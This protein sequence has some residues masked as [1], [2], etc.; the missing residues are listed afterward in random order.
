LSATIKPAKSVVPAA[1]LND[2]AIA[3]VQIYIDWSALEPGHDQFSP[4]V[5]HA[6]D[7]AFCEADEHDKF[8]VLDVLPGFYSPPWALGITTPPACAS[9]PYETGS[10]FAFCFAYSYQGEAPPR[11]LALPWDQ[12][13]L[14]N[15]FSFLQVIKA[16]YEDNAEFSMIAAAGPTSVSE[17]MS[18]PNLPGSPT[19]QCSNNPNCD[20]ALLPT[21]KGMPIDGSDLNMWTALGYTPSLYESAWGQVFTQYAKTLFSRQY[22]SFSLFDG[23]AIPGTSQ[24]SATLYDVFA[25]GKTDVGP[26]HFAFQ[27]DG[28]APH[29]SKNPPTHYNYLRAQDGTIAATGFQTPNPAKLNADA[30]TPE[31]ALSGALGSGLEADV[32]YLEFYDTEVL[33]PN[34]QILPAVQ[35][36]LSAVAGHWKISPPPPKPPRPH[37]HGTT[38]T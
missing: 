16:R 14:S 30:P 5:F 19:D 3:G 23:L 36:V 21:Y 31:T 1:I 37:C 25:L 11:A 38:C 28:V 2:P 26:G 33:G 34:G 27:G 35:R 15:W 7:A 32:N 22:I 9:T 8:V 10:S 29:E 17:E 20:E 18:M 4:T 6:L 13:Y 24:L 12:T